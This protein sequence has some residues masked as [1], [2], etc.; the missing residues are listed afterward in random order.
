VPYE[1]PSL[2]AYLCHR[3][4]GDAERQRAR[5]EELAGAPPSLSLAT[6]TWVAH[7]RVS[8]ASAAV[9][10]GPMGLV[11]HGETYEAG[12]Q[13]GAI[14]SSW[15]VRG[16]AV[17]GELNG[18]FALLVAD[19]ERDELAVVTDRLGSR[20]LFCSTVDGGT[21]ISSAFA[22]HRRVRRTVDP[23]GVMSYLVN[24][25]AFGGRTVL[26]G[27]RQLERASVHRF[28]V[29]GLTATP[30]W[31]VRFEPSPAP[32]DQ[33]RRELSDRLA[34]AVERCVFDRPTPFL[35]LSGGKDSRGIG[36][37]LRWGAEVDG[38]QCFS[39]VRGKPRAE[40][41]EHVAAQLAG[42]LGYPHRLVQSYDGD[43]VA[44]VL[45]N[46]AAGEGNTNLVHE[47]AGWKAMAEHFAAADRPVVLTGDT[48][49]G[50]DDV[51]LH[52]PQDVLD[53]LFIQNV[54]ATPA[55]RD[56]LP[57]PTYRE[58]AEGLEADRD[59]IWSR[60]AGID[61]LHDAADFLNIDQR[62]PYTILPWREAFTGRSATVRRPFLDNDLLDLVTV[63]PTELRRG[64]RLYRRALAARYPE[65][66]RVPLARD[67]NFRIDH[68]TEVPRHEAALRRLIDGQS[69]VVDD[70]VPPEAAHR[71]LAAAVQSS[72]Q[73]WRAPAR[74]AAK[75]VV[76]ASLRTRVRS[77]LPEP[78]VLPLP[79]ALLLVRLLIL[80]AGLPS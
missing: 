78:L 36:A 10:T 28:G 73:R 33:L 63:L 29:D 38:V 72:P 50:W 51:T 42:F 26:D 31:L 57:G 34:A 35:A 66:A 17:A 53:A 44:T 20:R 16:D 4:D 52:T 74:R 77:R 69:S 64:K 47:V 58:L 14:A 11:L 40:C 61:D 75:R 2:T 12:E 8:P 48:A 56:V 45:D 37:E 49:L 76:P 46:A 39:F 41:D 25:R 21:L 9:D 67:Q 19:R 7:V 27:V 60:C 30:H 1:P 80:R 54:A 22:P 32:E 65:L 70:L 62:L 3:R 59:A 23:T 71:L 13:G 55:L 6:A 43:L 18:S 15:S 79:P 68:P 24:G 5:F